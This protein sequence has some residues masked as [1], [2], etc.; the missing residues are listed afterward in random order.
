MSTAIIQRRF[1]GPEVLELVDVPT[2]IAE[3]LD[4]D[5]VLVRVAY[6]GVNVIDAMTRSGGGTAAAGVVTLP[7]TPGWD[8][9]GTVEAIGPGVVD[10]AVG[11][12]VFGLAR[13]PAAGGTYA[14]YVIVPARHLIATP[15][16]LTD[17]QAGALPLAAMTAWQAL[18][19]TTAVQPGQRVLISGAAGGVGHLAVQIAHHLGA[20]V[21]AVDSAT[22]LD[23][24]RRLG[25]DIAVDF[26]DDE[27]MAQLE[28][29]PA[30]ITLSLAAGSREFAVRATRRG[31][32]IVALGG[33]ARCV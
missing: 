22:K 10:L 23:Q 1:G 6:A 28:A 25:A 32:V 15:A 19:D 26:R 12:R 14:Q 4:A 9:A 20:T 30:D 17:E 27:A 2:P 21:V 3:Q 8:V 16:T 33:G 24:L 31:G 13:F 11:E 5:E 7:Y 18:G 29:D